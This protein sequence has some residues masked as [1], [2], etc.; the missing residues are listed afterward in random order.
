MALPLHS[1]SVAPFTRRSPTGLRTTLSSR[2]ML[3]GQKNRSG[4]GSEPEDQNG[5][6]T[7]RPEI[8]ERF[9][10]STGGSPVVV[11]ERGS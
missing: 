6:A 4:N 3:V 7:E 1:V 11:N 5:K 9:P 10:E 2:R 8:Q